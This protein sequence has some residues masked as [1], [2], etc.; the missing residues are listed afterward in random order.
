MGEIGLKQGLPVLHCDSQS[1]IVLA[2]NLVFHVKTKHI[3]VRHH[4]VWDCLANKKF[5][6]VKIHTSKN[7]VDALTKSLS[8]AINFSNVGS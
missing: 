7:A 1:A 4:F 8:P 5:N 3:D 6:L 2:K